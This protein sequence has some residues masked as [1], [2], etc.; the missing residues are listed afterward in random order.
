MH[1]GVRDFF[2]LLAMRTGVGKGSPN[3]NRGTDEMAFA[4]APSERRGAKHVRSCYGA[5]MT[6]GFS[7]FVALAFIAAAAIVLYFYLAN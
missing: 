1:S 3:A 4:T 2:N 5:T 6:T 7:T